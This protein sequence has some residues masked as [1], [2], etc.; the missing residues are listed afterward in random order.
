MFKP[1]PRKRLLFV[2][3]VVVA[4]GAAAIAYGAIPGSDGIIHGCYQKTSG[5]LHVIG[6]NPTVGGGA[7][8]IG[9]QALNWNQVGPTGPIGAT[10]QTG[11]TGA[12]GAT[13]ATGGPGATGAS[14]PAG[15]TG[16]DGAAGPSDLYFTSD[17]GEIILTSETKTVITRNV[18]AGNYAI[19][20]KLSLIAQNG[21]SD[22]RCVMRANGVAIDDTLTFTA[23]DQREFIAMQGAAVMATD[24]P[25]LV[26]CNES[27]D[28]LLEVLTLALSAIKVTTIH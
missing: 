9:E 17:L 24:G 13:G 5:T 15:A 23:T 12:T 22:A 7:C 6:T 25:I 1:W 18:P 8:G 3:T 4:G 27:S 2:A 21:D 20:A 19:F 14:G 16:A 11:P 28:N 10:G 26:E